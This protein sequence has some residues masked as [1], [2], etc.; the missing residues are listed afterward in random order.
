MAKK[1]QQGGFVFSTNPDFQLEPDSDPVETP[2]PETQNLRIWLE[3]MKGGKEATLIKGFAGNEADLEALAK[4]LKSKCAS[5]GNAKE[6][7]IILQGDHRDKVLDILLAMGF[8]K[9][10]KAGS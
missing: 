10:K 3:R 2:A 7:N 6:G 4:L 9:T 8:K 1:Q 5:G